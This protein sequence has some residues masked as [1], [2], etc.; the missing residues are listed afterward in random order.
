V[1]TDFTED[2]FLGGRLTI[3]QPRSG[4][5]AGHD[6]VLLAAAVP[7]SGGEHVLELGAGSG[8]VSLC[9]T[10]RVL[11]IAARGIEIDPEL[12]RLANENAARNRLADRA[13]FVEGDAESLDPRGEFFDHVFFNPPFHPDTGQISPYSTRD[14][15]RRDQGEMVSRWT[16]LGLAATREGGTV[17]AIVRADRQQEVVDIVAGR[18]ASI[19]PLFPRKG[20]AP[21]RVI[22]RIVKGGVAPERVAAGLIL[23]ATDGKPTPEADAI[24]RHMAP[25]AFA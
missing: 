23:H 3:A 5:R 10:A 8:V 11:G 12:V 2:G 18:G 24:L 19:L 22:I 1:S 25:L 9:L 20:E 14:R 17:T 16:R 15:A 13:R 7:A 21:K 6:A 4:F